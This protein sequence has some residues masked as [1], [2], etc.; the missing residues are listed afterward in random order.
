MTDEPN[1]RE[2]T[3][4]VSM[5]RKL[6]LGNYESADCFVSISGVRAGMTADDLGPLMATGKVAWEAVR[7]ELLIGLLTEELGALESPNPLRDLAGH[8]AGFLVAGH[9]CLSFP[10]G[11]LRV[12]TAWAI[13]PSISFFPASPANCSEGDC[14]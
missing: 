3:I 13:K 5:S 9:Y 11:L 8:H 10:L 1:E 12:C 6:N 2:P 14:D 7:A 4:S